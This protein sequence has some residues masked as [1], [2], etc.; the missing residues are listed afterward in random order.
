MFTNYK[1]SVDDP[2]LDVQL[3]FVELKCHYLFWP[4]IKQ[5]HICGLRS[6]DSMEQSHS[7]CVV[8]PVY[9]TLLH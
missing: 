6:S 4:T 1:Y 2:L 8:L 3:I 5:C 9:S 7:M